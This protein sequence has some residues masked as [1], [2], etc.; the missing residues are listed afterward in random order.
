MKINRNEELLQFMLRKKLNHRN[1]LLKYMNCLLTCGTYTYTNF[2]AKKRYVAQP[3]LSSR[4]LCSYSRTSQNVMEPKGSLSCSQQP[5]TSPSPEPD[6][7]IPYHINL[8]LS[9]SLSD[10]FNI[11]H[12][13]MSLSFVWF[14]TD[15]LYAFLFYTI[16]D[17]CSV[18]LILPDLIILFMLD[19]E[20][21][22]WS[23]SSCSFL[24][25]PVILSLF[26]RNNFFSILFS[27]TLNLCL[28]LNVKDLFPFTAQ[29]KITF[30]YILIFF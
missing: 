23:S 25:P 7:F 15:I 1:L 26:G 6:Q 19:E 3:F 24:Q 8:S 30:L 28:S 29:G 27:Y 18:H 5:S 12:P 17:T 10:P 2:I 14:L 22:L 9:L 4:Q 13:P 20:Y 11:M 21:K 16:R